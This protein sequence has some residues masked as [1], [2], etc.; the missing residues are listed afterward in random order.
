MDDIGKLIEPRHDIRCGHGY[1]TYWT[2]VSTRLYLNSSIL[3]LKKPF[4]RVPTERSINTGLT[5][6]Y[7]CKTI[8]YYVASRST[9]NFF[10]V[11]PVYNNLLLL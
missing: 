7:G 1:N 10:L 6:D 11:D 2:E 4:N 3:P 5:E 9:N 8:D